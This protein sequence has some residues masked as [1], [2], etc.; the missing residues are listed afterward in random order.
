MEPVRFI[1]PFEVEEPASVA[2]VPKP[3]PAPGPP[4]GPPAALLFSSQGRER[5]VQRLIH[6]LAILA[7][8][9]QQHPPVG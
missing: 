8:R 6:D 9:Q 1:D 3:S 7:A 2:P 5:E 4:A